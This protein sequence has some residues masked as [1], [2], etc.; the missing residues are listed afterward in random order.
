MLS[1]LN[2]VATAIICACADVERAKP[3]SDSPGGCVHSLASVALEK[4]CV[5]GEF[6][7]KPNLSGRCRGL[8]R[9]LPEEKG[10]SSVQKARASRT[11]CTSVQL[12]RRAP[13]LGYIDSC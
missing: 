5:S 10:S 3:R 11:I 4:P 2:R 8:V 6:I 12:D 9:S 13:V 7:P 1:A